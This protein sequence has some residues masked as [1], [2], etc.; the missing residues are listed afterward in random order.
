MPAYTV[1]GPGVER[2]AAPGRGGGR[3]GGVEGEGMNDEAVVQV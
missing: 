2:S 1:A 3:A